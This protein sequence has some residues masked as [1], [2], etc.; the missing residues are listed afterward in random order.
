VNLKSF[1]RYVDDS[2]ARFDVQNDAL[3]FLDVLNKQHENIQYTIE[4]ENEEKSLN[5]LDISI[6]NTTKGK[7]QF[8]IHRKEAITNVQ[9]KPSSCHDPK[10][11]NGVF[12]GFVDR[13]YSLCSD[14]YLD[15]EI[16]FLTQNF[17]DNGYNETS[18]TSIIKSVKQKKQQQQQQPPDTVQKIVSLPWIPGVS[19]K[20]KNAFKK[21]GYKTVFKSNK[22][23]KDILTAKTKPKLPANSHPGVYK[24]DCSC[25][26]AYVGE[27]KLQ[28]STRVNQHEKAAFLG[29]WQK[30]AIA[31]HTKSCDGV[32]E[33]N[34]QRNTIKVES[35]YFDRKVR[36]ALE[37]QYHRCNPKYGGINQDDG[38]YV[39][40]S[41]WKPLMKYCKDKDTLLKN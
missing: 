23:L 34:N 6:I 11:L 27:T 32:I 28:I 5:F 18:L 7:Y 3:R 38:T 29:Q 16:K 35:R 14:N 22:N 8:K 13:A 15:E 37:I 1:K 31:E 10:V 40:T 21:S 17:I 2:H 12:R 33:W 41:F 26:K 4:T 9:L 25:G 36:E 20:L 39:T 24:V 30:S 19:T